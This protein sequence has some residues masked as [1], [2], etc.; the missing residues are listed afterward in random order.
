MTSVTYKKKTLLLS[1]ASRGLKTFYL[2]ETTYF[3]TQSG[4]TF[5]LDIFPLTVWQLLG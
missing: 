3:S 2:D 5:W 4:V 1:E